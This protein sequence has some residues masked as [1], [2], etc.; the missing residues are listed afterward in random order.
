MGR[1]IVY[2]VARPWL[3]LDIVYKQT[4]A[5]RL[6]KKLEKILHGF[7]MSVIK[8]RQENFKSNTESKKK[9]AMLD[10]L[11]TAKNNGEFIDDIGIRE[12][13]DTFMFEVKQNFRMLQF[14]QY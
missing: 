1:I 13:V 11:L 10:L 2:R 5:Y 12:E 8:N 4:C 6:E 7:S 3:F 9:L 14:L